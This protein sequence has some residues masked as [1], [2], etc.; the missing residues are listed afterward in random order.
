MKK[1]GWLFASHTWGHLNVGEISMERLQRDAQNFKENVDLVIGGDR[2]Y[3]FCIR[4]RLN[5]AEDYSGEKFQ[6]PEGSGLYHFL[7]L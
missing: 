7:F 1:N 5:Q 6:F 4:G 2:H 3:H